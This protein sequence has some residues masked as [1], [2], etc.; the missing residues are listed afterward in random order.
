MIIDA[1]DR[2]YEVLGTLYE[3][4][5][6]TAYLCGIYNSGSE[7]RYTIN[8]VSEQRLYRRLVRM[9]SASEGAGT[10]FFTMDDKLCLV[11][12]YNTRRL[13]DSFFM[14]DRIS[15]KS[16]ENLFLN[17]VNACIESSL[18]YQIGRAHV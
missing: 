11:F 18:P 5:A 4:K 7:K 10:D 15:L 2:Q 16:G 6:N 9:F 8:V 13:F 1:P 12:E 3:G 14:R 17:I